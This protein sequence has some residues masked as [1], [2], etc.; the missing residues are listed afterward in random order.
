MKY[1]EIYGICLFRNVMY[2]NESI[3]FGKVSLIYVSE[4]RN[5]CKCIRKVCP[6]T[7]NHPYAPCLFSFLARANYWLNY[8]QNGRVSSRV[9]WFIF[10]DGIR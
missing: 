3:L 9:Y 8:G 1:M 10:C 4:M 2:N 7:A 6:F 5:S